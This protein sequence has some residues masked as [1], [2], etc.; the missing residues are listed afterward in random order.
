MWMILENNELN[1]NN[2][3]SSNPIN[4]MIAHTKYQDTDGRP[5]VHRERNIDKQGNRYRGLFGGGKN[6][7]EIE[8]GVVVK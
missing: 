2:S 1:D 3:Q 7:S 6:A 5:G 8:G 4:C